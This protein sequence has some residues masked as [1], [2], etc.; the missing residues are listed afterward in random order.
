MRLKAKVRVENRGLSLHGL[1]AKTKYVQSQLSIGR[2]EIKTQTLDIEESYLFICSAQNLAGT[3][4]ELSKANVLDVKRRC[5]DEGKSTLQLKE[6][7]HN[8]FIEAKDPIELKAFLSVMGKVLKGEEVKGALLGGMSPATLKQVTKPKTKMVIT[9]RKEYPVTAGFPSSLESLTIV[10]A[11]LIQF[12]KRMFKLRSLTALD[13]CNNCL[14]DIPPE[15][16]HL[17]NLKELS[18]AANSIQVVKSSLIES[19]PTSLRLL[20]LTK[21]QIEVI[22]QNIVRLVYLRVLKI[23]GNNLKRLPF[24]LGKIGR[25]EELTLSNNNVIALPGSLAIDRPMLEVLEVSGNPLLTECSPGKN[26]LFDNLAFPRLEDLCL[27]SMYRRGQFPT[28]E[29]APASVVAKMAS[30]MTCR[31][32]NVCFQA[33]AV[34]LAKVSLKKL[35]KLVSKSEGVG[36]TVMAE[37]VMCSKACCAKFSNNPFAF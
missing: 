11:K 19:L 21:N 12:D 5:A 25:L 8:I 6:P 22:P 2:K 31:C 37:A 29:E 27:S 26:I 18:V 33:R 13:L 30:V 4:Y 24:N 20:D 7:P 1:K 15:I 35:S 23:D 3:K 9:S 17:K 36:D 32:G 34:V 14:K 16:S 28:D 10:N